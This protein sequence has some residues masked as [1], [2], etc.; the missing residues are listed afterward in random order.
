MSLV[1]SAEQFDWFDVLAGSLMLKDWHL[2]VTENFT[3]FLRWRVF[4]SSMMGRTDASS[5]R[6]QKTSFFPL[7]SELLVD[8]L[9]PLMSKKFLRSE[10]QSG[11][12][13][14]WTRVALCRTPVLISCAFIYTVV[15]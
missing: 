15:N 8:L 10:Y 5:G 13:G 1:S 12:P 7:S 6:D 2:A 9:V 4:S 3:Y 11:A 14:L